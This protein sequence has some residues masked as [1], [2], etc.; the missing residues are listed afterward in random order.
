VKAV[1]KR[2][3]NIKKMVW[4]INWPATGSYFKGLN[5]RFKNNFFAAFQAYIR[6]KR[7]GKYTFYTASNDGSELYINKRIVVDNDGIHG[8]KTRGG[9]IFLKKGTANVHVYF[10]EAGGGAGLRVL[11]AGPG[12][13]KRLLDGK[14]VWTRKDFT[15]PPPPPRP[16]TR[17]RRFSPPRPFKLSAKQLRKCG[18]KKGLET[19]LALSLLQ[20]EQPGEVPGDELADSNEAGGRRRRR[21]RKSRRRRRRKKKRGLKKGS[22]EQDIKIVKKERLVAM[23]RACAKLRL[24]MKKAKLRRQRARQRK[25][26]AAR[27]A[28]QK[29]MLKRKEK[30]DKAITREKLFKKNKLI[31]KRRKEKN[32]KRVKKAQAKLRRAREDNAKKK[33]IKELGQKKERKRR[34]ALIKAR[35]QA[36]LLK[37]MKAKAV[38]RKRKKQKAINEAMS[39][40]KRK[41]RRKERA[42]KKRLV[43]PVASLPSD[44]R[45]LTNVRFLVATKRGN[46][47]PVDVLKNGIVKVVNS[48]YRFVSLDGIM[49]P[50][51]YPRRQLREYQ[52]ME[53]SLGASTDSMNDALPDTMESMDDS[54]GVSAESMN[55]ETV[56]DSLGGSNDDEHADRI[57]RVFDIRRDEDLKHAPQLGAGTSSSE[58]SLAV[59]T[60]SRWSEKNTKAAFKAIMRKHNN[61]DVWTLCA[62]EGNLCRARG[63]YK[64]KF[65][66]KGRFRYRVSTG[67]TPCS[68]KVF[69]DPIKGTPKKCYKYTPN[70]RRRRAKGIFARVAVKGFDAKFYKNIKASNLNQAMKRS[71]TPGK[72]FFTQGIHYPSTGGHWKGLDN[73][74][75]DHFSAEFTGRLMIR[76]TGRYHFWLSSD[77]GSKLK[78]DKKTVINND[79]LHGMSTKHASAVLL[80]GTPKISVTFFENGGGAGLMLQW[81]G[82]GFSRRVMS[83]RFVGQKKPYVKPGGNWVKLAADGKQ[84][85]IS[86]TTELRFGQ[87]VYWVYKKLKKGKIACNTK[88][89]GGDPLHGKRKHCWGLMKPTSTYWRPC[90]A[91]GQRCHGF[92]GDHKMR[93]GGRGKFAYLVTAGTTPCTTKV[94]GDPAPGVKKTCAI[95]EKVK[96]RPK[97]KK[98]MKKIYARRRSQIRGLGLHRPAA[99][100]ST[101]WGGVASRAVDGKT[102]G[103]Y[104]AGSC[105]HTQRQSNPWWRVAMKK[106]K[107]VTEV[108]VWN[109]TDCCGNRLRKLEV[110][111]GDKPYWNGNRA[112]GRKVDVGRS[113][114]I[115]CPRLQGK[116]VFVVLR[117]T[118]YLTLCEVQVF[119]MKA[120]GKR[121]RKSKGKRSKGGKGKAKKGKPKYSVT[122]NLNLVGVHPSKLSSKD[123]ANLKDV[124]AAKM[125]RVCGPNGKSVCTRADVLLVF[126]TNGRGTTVT[127][128]VKVH[129]KTA[130]RAGFNKMKATS[131]KVWK[132]AI[133][134]KGSSLAK[135]S[136]VNGADVKVSEKQRIRRAIKGTLNLVGIHPS[137]LT[138]KDKKNLKDAIAAKVGRVCGSKSNSVCTSADVTLIIRAHGRNATRVMFAVKVHSAAASANGYNKVRGVTA[139]AMRDALTKKGGNLGKIKG[140]SVILASP[141]KRARKKRVSPPPN[142][143]MKL[144][145]EWTSSGRTPWMS[146]TPMRTQ[147]LCVLSGVIRHRKHYRGSKGPRTIGRVPLMCKPRKRQSFKLS[148]GATYTVRVTIDTKGV[149]KANHSPSRTS[150]I[151]L[152]GIYY[153]NSGGN[154]SKAKSAAKKVKGFGGFGVKKMGPYCILSGNV[155]ARPG[156]K[157]GTVPKECRPRQKHIFKVASNIPKALVTIDTSGIAKLLTTGPNPVIKKFFPSKKKKAV[158]KAAKRMN[159]GA[160]KKANKKLKKMTKKA[161]NLSMNKKSKTKKTET[162]ASKKKKLRNAEKAMSGKASKKSSTS[163]KQ[164]KEQ[165]A[166]AREKAHKKAKKSKSTK[167]SK[168]ERAKAG[169][170]A[171]K[172]S[173]KNSK[174]SVSLDES[175]EL[176]QENVDAAHGVSQQKL[177]PPIR[178]SLAGI[179]YSVAEHHYFKRTKRKR[180]KHG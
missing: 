32:N 114:I 23:Q 15:S 71:K 164:S 111:V 157:L 3:P 117:Q 40:R 82:P 79:H 16:K 80:R 39:K 25:I 27:R 6:I 22:R 158:V 136:G 165:R 168:A 68:N 86:R 134:K 174:M 17:R 31:S 103:H 7:A 60:K 77:D 75:R 156:K 8:M 69:G 126:K 49:F 150:S 147:N 38:E 4:R 12:F 64:M 105:T 132:S 37:A 106:R 144:S 91:E 161:G 30:R 143:K 159:K 93:F 94:F 35:K 83:G 21:R 89:F 52:S 42:M 63:K 100:I 127:Y 112:C 10:F 169:E 177:S 138:A 92:S 104:G 148:N 61:P 99:Q 137:Q 85:V 163:G 47:V 46:T 110:R 170:K 87:G 121:G 109:R 180:G 102:N 113:K 171:H 72:R 139:T 133:A 151:S 34:N 67:N 66:A 118:Q 58:Y 9:T 116:F 43:E 129:T 152:S 140:T 115:R 124:I 154:D 11:W 162:K 74:Y 130:S 1:A 125:G 55:D 36:A 95:L 45:P 57:V 172:K 20:V 173:K 54:H 120:G 18:V 97:P 13:R 178:V 179:V 167:Q 131:A 33:R 175:L 96:P 59:S 128:S 44:C 62:R 73:S 135:V 50:T 2:S 28:A 108:K 53:S 149:M 5:G 84:F 155:I 107:A 166:K 123:K 176:L 141:L 70:A 145:K 101:G 76:K 48:N 81:S 122:G 29:K 142:M 41:Q 14:S 153:F 19:S 146:L 56:D 65:G 24:K 51:Q 160:K 90:A 78:I 98:V 26:A 88:T 119:G